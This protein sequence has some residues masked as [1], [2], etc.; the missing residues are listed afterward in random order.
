M[1][2]VSCGKFFMYLLCLNLVWFIVGGKCSILV[3]WLVLMCVMNVLSVLIM[4]LNCLL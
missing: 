1:L 2:F 4:C 3:C